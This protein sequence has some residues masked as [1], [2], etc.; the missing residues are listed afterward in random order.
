MI[1]LLKLPIIKELLNNIFK[2]KDFSNFNFI[3]EN[4]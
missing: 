4:I 3:G 2:I 1:N